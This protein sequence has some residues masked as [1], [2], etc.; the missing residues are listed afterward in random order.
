MPS[1]LPSMKI[2]VDDN[3]T[4]DST[5]QTH[6]DESP[7]SCLDSPSG[8]D[9]Q[10]SSLSLSRIFS[11]MNLETAPSSCNS[12]TI[13]SNQSSPSSTCKSNVSLSTSLL[14]TSFP[15]LLAPSHKNKRSHMVFSSQSEEGESTVR[16]IL[17]S[18]SSRFHNA[19]V[20]RK[21]HN[22]IPKQKKMKP[23]GRVCKSFDVSSSNNFQ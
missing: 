8:N 16:E 13:E 5:T 17:S 7:M 3:S 23:N 11:R 6:L 14:S 10:S 9:L 2:V 18:I 19:I 1:K 20:E 22:G 12:P 4:L 15:V 21:N